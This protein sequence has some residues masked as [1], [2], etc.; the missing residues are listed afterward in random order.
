MSIG[1]NFPF[2][3]YDFISVPVFPEPKNRKDIA[4]DTVSGLQFIK[5][6][7]LSGFGSAITNFET[8]FVGNYKLRGCY[9]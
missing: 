8:I 1:A 2:I 9:E 7:S 6:L 4:N 3:I 5:S